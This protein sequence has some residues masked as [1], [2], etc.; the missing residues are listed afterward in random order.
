MKTTFTK[1]GITHLIVMGSL[2]ISNAQTSITGFSPKGQLVSSPVTI[3]G[4]FGSSVNGVFFGSTKQS[5][6]ISTSNSQI[7]CNVPPGATFDYISVLDQ[8]GYGISKEKFVPRF[9]G[10]NTLTAGNFTKEQKIDYSLGGYNDIQNSIVVDLNNDGK[11]DIVNLA[12]DNSSFAKREIIIR[13]A[14]N[15]G[16]DP[17]TTFSNLAALTISGSEAKLEVADVTNDGLPEL[18]L[19]SYDFSLASTTLTIFK[20]TSTGG[21]VSFDPAV[22]ITVAGNGLIAAIATGDFNIDGKKDV[23]LSYNG[24]NQLIILQ[25]DISNG[26][27]NAGSFNSQFPVDADGDM[28]T[29]AVSDLDGDGMVDIVAGA[30]VSDNFYTFLNNSMG[31]IAFETP[32]TYI[33]GTFI[34]TL[35]LKIADIDGD[36][37]N[38]IILLQNDNTNNGSITFLQ[39][40]STIGGIDIDIANS[41]FKQCS[42]SDFALGDLD[43]DGK[44]DLV[45]SNYL[46]V[47]PPVLNILKNLALPGI[48]YTTNT[49][50]SSNNILNVRSEES[51]L[52]NLAIADFNND[53]KPDLTGTQVTRLG[54]FANEIGN[55]VQPIITSLSTISGVPGSSFTVFGQNLTG[56]TD[57]IIPGGLV[58][59]FSFFP[60]D[61]NK[62]VATV[63]LNQNTVLSGT[64]L[65]KNGFLTSEPSDQ[66][67]S[68]VVPPAPTITGVLSNLVPKGGSVTVLGINFSNIGQILPA[69]EL[70]NESNPFSN[71][72]LAY[73]VLSNNEIRIDDIGSNF[74]V[75][76]VLDIRF[77]NGV[78]GYLEDVITVTSPP[79]PTISGIQPLS[80]FPYETITIFGENLNFVNKI[81]LSNDNEDKNTQFISRSPN[82]IEFFFYDNTNVFTGPITITNIN[83]DVAIST[84]IFTVLGPPPAIVTSTSAISGFP[85]D[86]I[87][88]FGENL[89]EIF[90]ISFNGSQVDENNFIEISNNAFALKLPP[91]FNPSPDITSSFIFQKKQGVVTTV[92]PQFTLLTPPAITITSFLPAA[93]SPGKYVTFSGTNL[94]YIEQIRHDNPIDPYVFLLNEAIFSADGTTLIVKV[95][96]KTPNNYFPDPLNT[97]SGQVLYEYYTNT[98]PVSLLSTTSQNLEILAYPIPTV[99]TILGPA[100][101]YPNSEVT[102]IGSN[103]D[104]IDRYTF[105]SADENCLLKEIYRSIEN[106][107]LV[108]VLNPDCSLENFAFTRDAILL[109]AS[110]SP[111]IRNNL[112]YS[113]NTPPFDVEPFDG[114]ITILGI[115][116]SSYTSADRIV[117][118]IASSGG[119]GDYVIVEFSNA[120]GDFSESDNFELYSIPSSELGGN[121]S[122]STKNLFEVEGGGIDNRLNFGDAGLLLTSSNYKLRISL[123]EVD[124]VLLEPIFS[125]TIDG[126]S[127]TRIP[128]FNP[129]PNNT[130]FDP[131]TGNEGTEIDIYGYHFT[132]SSITG[133][134]FNNVLAS[135]YTIVSDNQIKVPLPFGDV[136]GKIRILYG[137]G[138]VAVSRKD[139]GTPGESCGDGIQGTTL[140]GARLYSAGDNISLAVALDFGDIDP[141]KTPTGAVQL[142]NANGLFSPAATIGVDN[143]GFAQFRTIPLTIPINTPSSDNYAVR[144]VYL[145]SE[146]G[147]ADIPYNNI[148][149]N[150]IGASPTITGITIND[151]SF[152]RNDTITGII[153]TS[154]PFPIVNDFVVSLQNS[155]LGINV[156]IQTIVGFL[157]MPPVF[158]Y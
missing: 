40:I 137:V 8:N 55:N 146:G 94:Q 88:F 22:T 133:I 60:I 90:A 134:T 105:P 156:D 82:K 15:F 147:C 30:R 4:V 114:Q 71:S 141:N 13:Q 84:E 149:I 72:S 54:I 136:N 87:T 12:I 1:F 27:V 17:S 53:G 77:G 92:N 127:F 124:P 69:F 62:L 97:I 58:S 78:N 144:I 151:N 125:N 67:F 100:K 130:N 79:P 57:I 64:L 41:V 89:N 110:G 123:G 122:I 66:T 63:Y 120:D 26:I 37:K 49:L 153:S 25:N 34:A 43:G 74:N 154:M 20:N 106:D 51:G 152:L 115:D 3:T 107:T 145:F 11:N 128:V 29:L 157:M 91:F 2:L 101:I 18:L 28:A 70:F 112:D 142:S 93:Q 16:T 81:S 99:T 158:T 36:S 50:F 38:D 95:S 61:D 46:V 42:P 68:I 52:K 111:L 139:F 24:R 140:S 113:V 19:G 148:T 96:S 109:F 135:S 108:L 14:I 103:F 6:Y 9:S 45:I 150:G 5:N 48:E 83:M 59:T 116:K 31:S 39:N 23:V 76:E 33:L 117:L 126:I 32:T 35:G 132:E 65:L 118:N 56:V 104:G 85:K 102:I 73:T 7:V 86:I 75:G 143:F 44:P 47:N 138:G 10:N 98:A 80:A 129:N 131:F 21:A 155:V 121:V 119:F